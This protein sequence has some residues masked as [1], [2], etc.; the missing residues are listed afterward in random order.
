MDEENMWRVANANNSYDG[1]SPER[2]VNNNAVEVNDVTK[3]YTFQ[4]SLNNFP[5]L[6]TMGMAF[7]TYNQTI[8]P[9]AAKFKTGQMPTSSEAWSAYWAKRW[10][11]RLRWVRDFDSDL[12]RYF[13]LTD[14]GIKEALNRYGEDYPNY[15]D[16]IILLYKTGRNPHTGNPT[17]L[18]PLKV[19][20]TSLPRQ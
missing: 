14:R 12:Q 11:I 8:V 20:P 6:T 2:S 7:V 5:N 1:T 13:G 18:W 19:N 3:G 4:T 9:E 15:A 10:V 16:P 17:Y